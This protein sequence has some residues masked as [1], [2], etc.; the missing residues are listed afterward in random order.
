MSLMKLSSSVYLVTILRSHGSQVSAEH[1]L[2][3][4]TTISATVKALEERLTE[5][6]DKLESLPKEICQNIV[7]NKPERSYML[8]E[9]ASIQRLIDICLSASQDLKNRQLDIENTE[10]GLNET[11]LLRSAKQATTQTLEKCQMELTNASAGIRA[12]IYFPDSKNSS[13]E[14]R[15]PDINAERRRMEREV[16]SLRQQ[17]AICEESKQFAEQKRQ[18]IFERV[19]AGNQAS[20][21]IASNC[22]AD[23]VARDIKIGDKTYQALGQL[24]GITIQRTSQNHA[25]LLAP[26]VASSGITPEAR[27]DSSLQEQMA[28]QHESSHL[29]SRPASTYEA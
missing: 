23:I 17:L 12:E 20:Q 27:V 11:E 29:P 6:N 15:G 7:S 10:N 18:M 24:D 22:E 3:Y 1:I 9:K 14:W 25:A 5:M 2:S 19:S 26:H 28:P 16:E 21:I 8:E 4:Q 13:I